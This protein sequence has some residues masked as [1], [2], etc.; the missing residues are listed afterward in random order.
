M[1]V[2]FVYFQL[3][4]KKSAVELFVGNWIII[5]QTEF[6]GVFFRSEG[7]NASEFGSGVQDMA[8][9]DHS[10]DYRLAIY[11]SGSGA[12]FYGSDRVTYFRETATTGTS[13]TGVETRP[14]NITIRIWERVS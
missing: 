6:P 8:L 10:H 7:G 2:G 4:H 1:P 11:S 9:Q 3:P 5:S 12:V 14:V 13:G